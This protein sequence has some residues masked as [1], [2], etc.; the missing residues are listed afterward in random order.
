[1]IILLFILT[2]ILAKVIW[3]IYETSR[4][5]SLVKE[6]TEI[7]RRANYLISK[8]ATSPKQLMDADKYHPSFRENGQFIHV[9]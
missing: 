1:M 5:G 7:V 9:P 2:L 4:Q 3:V 6:Q 8:V